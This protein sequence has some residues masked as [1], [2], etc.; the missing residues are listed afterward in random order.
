M[1]E[2][3]TV[4]KVAGWLKARITYPRTGY[5]APPL[6]PSSPDATLLSPAE[7]EQLRRDKS[8]DRWI[9][10]PLVLALLGAWFGG[11]NLL[12]VAALAIACLWTAFLLWRNRRDGRPRWL[13]LLAFSCY[14]ALLAFLPGE[15]G[16]R[17]AMS[18]LA[19]GTF[20]TILGTVTFVLYLKKHPAPQAASAGGGRPWPPLI[21]R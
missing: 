11:R 6:T 16:E 12:V 2:E 21:Q 5:I 7:Q 1:A 10:G 4:G 9:W 3:A 8:Y 14:A 17:I 19:A 15:R 18:V 20:S 13:P